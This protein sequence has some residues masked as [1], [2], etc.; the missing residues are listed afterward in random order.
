MTRKTLAL[1]SVLVAGSIALAALIAGSMSPETMQLPI[2]WNLA[3]EPDVFARKW[4]ALLM[5]AGIVAA[6]SSLFYALPALEPRR[7]GLE[8]STG[9]YLW[10][11]VATLMVGAVVEVAVISEAF[12]WNIPA[13]RLIVG[14]VGAALILIGNQ[15]GKSR[16][17]YFLGL[18]TPWTLSS[19]EVW[20]KTHRLGGKLMVASGFAIVLTAL[21]SLP[22]GLSAAFVALA[23]TGCVAVPI[24][25]SFLIRHAGTGAKGRL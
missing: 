20:I 11:W 14:S 8:R 13:S 22:P 16:G 19:E 1:A 2:H 21:L 10:G 17:M 24:L 25:Y 18:R 6:V 9:L 5:P 23:L 3:G 4:T 12:G 15:M 7:E